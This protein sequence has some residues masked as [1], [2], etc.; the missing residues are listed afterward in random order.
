MRDKQKNN[1]QALV[2]STRRHQ[3]MDDMGC[4]R[5]LRFWLTLRQAQ[6]EE[7]KKSSW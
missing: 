4:Q 3:W 5:Q 1:D 7:K 6:G 2:V